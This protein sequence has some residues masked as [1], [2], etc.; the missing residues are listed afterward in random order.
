MHATVEVTPA[1]RAPWACPREAPAAKSSVTSGTEAQG[2]GHGFGLCR[3]GFRVKAVSLVHPGSSMVW[4][5]LTP[6][7]GG[8]MVR[9]QGCRVHGEGRGGDA[10]PLPPRHPQHPPPK[11]IPAGRRKAPVWGN[12]GCR[13]ALRVQSRSSISQQELLYPPVS[14]TVRRS[15]SEALTHFLHCPGR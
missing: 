4:E 2:L 9:M 14:D 7:R 11:G 6:R 13:W 8:G 12:L 15:H 1:P 10:A 3:V 5:F